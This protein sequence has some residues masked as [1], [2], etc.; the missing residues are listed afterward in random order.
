MGTST[1]SILTDFALMIQD[2]RLNLC[3]VFIGIK[4]KQLKYEM[5]VV[6]NYP[7]TYSAT[8]QGIGNRQ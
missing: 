5:W 6:S 2:K 8:R 3:S 1:E 4:S 7:L